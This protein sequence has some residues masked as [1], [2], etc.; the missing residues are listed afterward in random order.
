MEMVVKLMLASVV[1]G[2]VVAVV[3]RIILEHTER[4]E[5]GKDVAKER[6]Q[7]TGRGN[8]FAEPWSEEDV[9]FRLC[10]RS[11]RG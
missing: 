10:G 4:D 6:T 3:C 7:D 1:W 8:G 2:A 9:T 11:A 5:P